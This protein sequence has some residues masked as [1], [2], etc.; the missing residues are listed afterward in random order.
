MPDLLT[1]GPATER[2]LRGQF[3]MHRFEWP[4]EDGV[5]FHISH[6]DRIRLLRASGFEITDLVEIQAPPAVST[7]DEYTSG[8][9]ARRW[10]AEEVWRA[11]KI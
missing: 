6:G 11:R 10:P 8:E 5:E 2:L 7:C 9:R 1:E 4:D 3:G